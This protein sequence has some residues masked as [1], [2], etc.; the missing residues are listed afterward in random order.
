MDIKEVLYR[1]V[2]RVSGV[3][4]SYFKPETGFMEVGMDE[5]YMEE[6]ADDIRGEFDLDFSDEDF[7]A[8]TTL[9]QAIEFIERAL[10]EKTAKAE[11][12]GG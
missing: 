2:S 11:G 12:A 1:S 9:G 4:E 8:L 5:I 3:E 6:L 7:Q 10:A